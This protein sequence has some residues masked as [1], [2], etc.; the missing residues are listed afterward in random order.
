MAD[1]PLTKKDVLYDPQKQEVTLKR[2][3]FDRLV[4]F[5]QDLLDRVESAED[6]RDF[7]THRARRAEASA[8]IL[9]ALTT[10]VQESTAAIRHWLESHSIKELSELTGIP[11][12]TCHRIVNER[13][14]TRN[15]E[16]HHLADMLKV[17]AS[18]SSGASAIAVPG[19]GSVLVGS[20]S[21]QW[22]RLISDLKKLGVDVM[23]ATSGAEATVK[24]QQ[25]DPKLVVLDGSILPGLKISEV[26][27][28]TVVVVSQ[29]DEEKV[30]E[31]VK[32]FVYRKAS[33]D[34]TK[35]ALR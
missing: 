14:G 29:Q 21:R 17:A 26:M 5:V 13:L 10:R 24:V 25:C 33:E 32:G 22:W 20:A 16:F 9:Q 12:A 8:D 27:N 18:G 7:A 1:F 4:A 15:V 28:G 11:Y 19:P 34:A 30:G 23:T 2:E 6:A 31:F 3:K 35:T